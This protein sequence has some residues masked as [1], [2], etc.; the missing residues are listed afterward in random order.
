MKT[1]RE[2]EIRK[3]RLRLH[4][5]ISLYLVLKAWYAGVNCIAISRSE[6]LKFFAMDT[7]PESRMAEI[8]RDMKPWF[9]GFKPYY[10]ENNQTYVNWLFVSQSADLSFLPDGSNLST[11]S[12]VITKLIQASGGGTA[13]IA[14]LSEILDGP[15]RSCSKGYG[16][17]A[18]FAYSWVNFP[19]N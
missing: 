8:E 18:Y 11:G 19:S 7:T 16:D 10:R 13:R 6:L 3:Y 17:R 14:L 12:A 15:R 1:I 9:K 4:R 2:R 5:I